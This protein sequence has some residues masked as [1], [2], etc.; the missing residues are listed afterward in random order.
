MLHLC[1]KCRKKRGNKNMLINFLLL[2][3]VPTVQSMFPAKP[4]ETGVDV[5]TCKMNKN[6]DKKDDVSVFCKLEIYQSFFQSGSF[7]S[8]KLFIAA[9][10]LCLPIQTLFHISDTFIFL[11]FLSRCS[12]FYSCACSVFPVASVKSWCGH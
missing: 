4:S 2:L 9:A 7:R 10:L 5:V 8:I 12:F 11:S 3:T 6:T 1:S